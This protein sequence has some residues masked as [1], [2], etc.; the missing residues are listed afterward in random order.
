MQRRREL[1]TM[2]G[3]QKLPS[4]Y[5]AIE[6][7]ESSGT[8]WIDTGIVPDVQTW[9]R[10]KFVNLVTTGDVIFGYWDSE[11]TSWRMFNPDGSNNYLDLPSGDRT[12]Y[13]WITRVETNIYPNFLIELEIGNK[14]KKIFQND[15][16]LNDQHLS[17]LIT[18]EFY[19]TP[20]ESF[21]TTNKTLTLNHYSDTKNSSNRWYD[22]KI[23]NGDVLERHMIPCV[24]KSDNKPGMYDT[25]TKT[26]YTNAGTG[27][28]IVPA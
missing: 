14:F 4:A 9:A 23:Y 3:Q 10:L 20:I 21:V 18:T 25:V 11:M 6:Y 27:E 22:V 7:L 28:F 1:M 24:R 5:R 26:F 19:D 13:R 17:E 16:Y 15:G 12:T 8:Q 2:Q